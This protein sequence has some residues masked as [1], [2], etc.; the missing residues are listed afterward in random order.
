M[1]PDHFFLRSEW[2]CF[3]CKPAPGAGLRGRG[4]A[5]PCSAPHG[6]RR[7]VPLMLDAR[8]ARR[9]QPQGAGAED[10][11]PF[12]PSEGLK[13]P[14]EPAWVGSK[15]SCTPSPGLVSPLVAT[16]PVGWSQQHQCPKSGHTG[17]RVHRLQ[18]TQPEQSHGEGRAVAGCPRGS[19]DGD[20]AEDGEQCWERLS[21]AVGQFL[22]EEAP[23]APA[24]AALRCGLSRQGHG[25]SSGMGAATAGGSPVSCAPAGSD[26][27]SQG[28]F[29]AQFPSASP[30][31]WGNL[32]PSHPMLPGP[33]GPR[34]AP[35]QWGLFHPH[36]K[37]GLAAPRAS[38]LLVLLFPCPPPG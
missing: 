26:P 17:R 4:G 22:E 33:S 6:R 13:H 1:S 23:F 31:C 38:Q 28:C 36:P 18:H 32:Q 2:S 19:R 37:A 25:E 21:F 3:T 24:A 29:T 34:G 35:G 9:R 20:G 27:G 8:G 30:C 12:W 11:A 7:P 16:V 14:G 5:S 10:P 15:S